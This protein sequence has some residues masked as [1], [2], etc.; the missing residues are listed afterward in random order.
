MEKNSRPIQ[1]AAWTLLAGVIVYM[2]V[3]YVR[4]LGQKSNL[5]VIGQVEPFTLTNQLGGEVTLAD[6]KG[7]VWV[8]DI[9]FTRCMGP[10]PKMTQKMSDLQKRFDDKDLRFVTMTTDPEHDTPEILK[11][12]GQ[13]FDADP[14]RWFFLTGTKSQIKQLAQGSLKL[15]SEE[16]AKEDQEN[17]NDLF[18][19][20]TVFILVDKQ[21]RMRGQAYESLEPDFREKIDK[22]IQ[23]L[24]REKG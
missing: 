14:N 13:K 11:N 22:D 15:G 12:Y 7:K 6:L 3:S 9:I 20:N 2:C 24:L 18:I 5:P 23:A 10:C 8:T 21:G 17:P 1:I 16:K 19:H 4:E